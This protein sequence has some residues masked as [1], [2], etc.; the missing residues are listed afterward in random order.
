MVPAQNIEKREIGPVILPVMSAFCL[1]TNM[2]DVA[3]MGRCMAMDSGVPL[4]PKLPM[5][6]PTPT[7]RQQASHEARKPG[8]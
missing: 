4:C 6:G 2:S 7:L 3:G 1:R 8:K 5:A